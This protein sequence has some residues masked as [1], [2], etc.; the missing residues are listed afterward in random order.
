MDEFRR[1]VSKTASSASLRCSSYNRVT[2][3]RFCALL[4]LVAAASVAAI[5]QSLST[6]DYAHAER[7]MSYNTTPLVLHRV[8]RA[9]W[10]VENGVE[11]VWYRTTSEKGTEMVLIDPVAGTRSPCDLP[12]CRDAERQPDE[13]GPPPAR[14]ESRSPDGKSAAFI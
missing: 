2:M 12:A 7:F 9:T 10:V 5:A 6:A 8:T 3:K 13:Q 1:P 14:A 11:R 4:S